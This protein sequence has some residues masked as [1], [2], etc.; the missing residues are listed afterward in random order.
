MKTI[1]QLCRELPDS[2]PEIRERAHELG[3]LLAE[4]CL[5]WQ[6]RKNYLT[7]RRCLFRP[8][9]A[10]PLFQDMADGSELIVCNW[11]EIRMPDCNSITDAKAATDAIVAQGW[12][13]DC[14]TVGYPADAWSA[15]FLRPDQECLS[16]LAST[17][18]LAMSAAALLASEA[19]KEKR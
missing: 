2:E 3:A 12:Q 5:G 16:A 15:T 17:M 1:L 4:N 11:D 8:G 7:G 13:F 14:G 19:M 10:T 18:E 6:W 9:S